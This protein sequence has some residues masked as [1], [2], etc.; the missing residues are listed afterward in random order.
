MIDFIGDIHGHYDRLIALLEKLG[1]TKKN[2]VYK[3]PSRRVIFLGDYL[4]R[5]PDARS[6]DESLIFISFTAAQCFFNF[7]CG[8]I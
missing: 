2:G 1:Y 4:D 3:H 8:F 6:F 5:G 7:F